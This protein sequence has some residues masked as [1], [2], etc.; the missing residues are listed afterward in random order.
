MT[1]TSDPG[2]DL[3]PYPEPV[4]EFEPDRV[5]KRY[6]PLIRHRLDVEVAAYRACAWAAPRLLWVTPQAICMERC[7]PLL[8]APRNPDH[9]VQLHA[10]LVKLHATGWAHRDVSAPNIVLHPTRGVLLIDW[11]TAG[12][13]DPTRP[14]YDLHGAAAAGF[15]DK[16]LP[17][18]QRPDGV[19]WGGPGYDAPAK[20]WGG[21][22]AELRR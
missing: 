9:A 12:R 21:A 16:L 3:I 11:E 19:W 7:T 2:W 22:G 14:S 8:D 18:H 6:P 5:I 4:L 15:P 1:V 13:C 17:L 20:Y 10:L